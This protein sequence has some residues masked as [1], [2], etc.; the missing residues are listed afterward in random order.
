MCSGS[1]EVQGLVVDDHG[2]GL[3]SSDGLGDQDDVGHD[4]RVLEGEHLSGTSHS[5]LD[6][7]ADHGDTEFSGDPADRL[8]EL[9][10]CGDDP[11]LS[12][13]GLEDD[14]RRFGDTALGI[15]EE[16]LE[17]CDARFGSRLSADPHGT[18]VGVGVWHEL[19]AGHD[20]LDMVLGVAVAGEGHGA[21]P[22][23]VIASGEGDDGAPSGG[24]L[25]EFDSCLGC[26]CARG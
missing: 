17:V 15:L 2:Q 14:R 25:A 22:H 9:D 7:I 12:L 3:S 13:D 20:V 24:G 1:P 8:E 18:A 23:A 6:L 26:I 11:S 10:G 5:A 4:V 21:V 16:T 19:D